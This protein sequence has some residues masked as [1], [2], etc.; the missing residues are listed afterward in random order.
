MT[1]G[2][3]TCGENSGKN[4][5]GA[6]L[7]P[8]QGSQYVGMG[9]ELYGAFKCARETFEEAEEAANFRIS[10]LCFEGP[11]RSLNLTVNTQPAI[12]TVSVAALRVLRT[13]TGI[14]PGYV[15]GHSLGEYSALVAANAIDFADAVRIV[16]TRGELMQEAVPA[17]EGGMAVVL[18]LQEEVVKSICDQASQGD[19]VS[20]ANYNCAGQTVISGHLSAVTRA[21]RLAEEAGA[22]AA[23]GLPVS[24]PMHCSLMITAGKRLREFLDRIDMRDACIPLVSNVDSLPHT[25]GK[26]IKDL[27]VRHVSSPVRWEESMRTLLRESVRKLVEIGPR[28]VLSGLAKRIHS[29]FEVGNVEDIESLTKT[30]SLFECGK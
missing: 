9:K 23:T 18:G 11:L 16:R 21:I 25:E 7:F 27:L 26:E 20:I 6:L 24:A 1:L 30:K 13:E 5:V 8:G 4:G 15:C 3:N 14:C 19:R 10:T 29:G 28:K 12:L 2:G 22:K 17:G